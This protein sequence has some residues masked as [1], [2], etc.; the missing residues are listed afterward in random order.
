MS[1]DI[2]LVS[3]NW[4]VRADGSYRFRGKEKCL[5]RVCCNHINEKYQIKR[6]S[7]K[8]DRFADN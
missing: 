4:S 5:S 6:W 8:T 3:F 2:V 1:K 7:C